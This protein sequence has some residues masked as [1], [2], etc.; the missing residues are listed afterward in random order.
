MKKVVI[1]R[2]E[3]CC[4]WK[5]FTEISSSIETLFALL[6]S[7]HRSAKHSIKQLIIV[8]AEEPCYRKFRFS[9]PD[10]PMEKRRERKKKEAECVRFANCS[11][12]FA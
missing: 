8:T 10:K 12:T 6:L 7:F 5:L 4:S 1:H 2:K 3:D 9:R 11:T